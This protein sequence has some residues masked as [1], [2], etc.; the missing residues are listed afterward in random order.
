MNIIVS[1]VVEHEVRPTQ[2]IRMAITMW[3]SGKGNFGKYSQSNSIPKQIQESKLEIIQN[4]QHIEPLIHSI[5]FDETIPISLQNAQNNST[6]FH[7]NKELTQSLS[8]ETIFISIVSYRDSELK[9]TIRDIFEKSEYPARIFIGIVLQLYDG[10][11]SEDIYGLNQLYNSEFINSSK[12]DQ[13]KDLFVSN[14]R[15]IRMNASESRGPCYVRSLVNQLYLGEKYYLQI[16]AHMRFRP[17]FD[18]YLLQLYLQCLNL[19]KINEFPIITTYPPGYY[20]RNNENFDDRYP[21]DIRPTLLVS[22]F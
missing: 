22:L 9:Y 4:N 13:I 12:Y 20:Q 17:F 21:S 11:D 3:A 10:E 14:I 18:S 8:I 16:D 19:M 2:S 7:L 6:T 1:E 15:I 5:T